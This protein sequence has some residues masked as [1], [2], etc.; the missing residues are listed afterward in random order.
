MRSQPPEP[1]IIFLAMSAA[2]ASLGVLSLVH[3]NGIA[4]ARVPHCGNEL[5][6]AWGSRQ[7]DRL[8]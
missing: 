8:V 3:F 2:Y 6:D 4:N 7:T 5:P 1:T